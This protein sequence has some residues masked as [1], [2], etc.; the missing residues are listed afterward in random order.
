M[1]DVAIAV[2][3]LGKRYRIGT[4]PAEPYGNLRE[5]M[6]RALGSPLRRLHGAGRAASAVSEFWALKYAL[7]A[8]ITP[9]ASVAFAPLSAASSKLASADEI[10]ATRAVQNEGVRSA[11]ENCARQRG[12]GPIWRVLKGVT[13]HTPRAGGWSS[14]FVRPSPA[15]RQSTYVTLGHR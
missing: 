3:G 7:F 14:Y 11:T 6:M 8:A 10:G 12:S 4:G 9:V 5:S 15:C 1:S 2:E 13:W